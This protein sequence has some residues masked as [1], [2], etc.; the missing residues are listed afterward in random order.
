[1]KYKFL[2]ENMKRTIVIVLGLF[3]TGCAEQMMKEYQ[4]KQISDIVLQYGPPVSA[5]DMGDG[6]RAFMWAYNGQVIV[7]GTA[8]SSGTLI[9]GSYY[10]TTTITP[11]QAINYQCNYTMFATRSRTDI[12]GPAAWTIVGY[13]KPTAMC[14]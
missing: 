12:E 10:G 6:R 8:N 4:G 7:P 2:R 13:Q 11:S 14:Q 5:F 9:G 3:L 1:M